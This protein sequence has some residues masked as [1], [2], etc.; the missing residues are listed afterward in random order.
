[1]HFTKTHKILTATVIALG[2][3]A[4]GLGTWALIGSGES[5]TRAVATHSSLDSSTTTTVPA[6]PTPPPTGA[7]SDGGADDGADD[8]GGSGGG[9]PADS[10]APADDGNAGQVAP[11]N[12]GQANAGNPGNGPIQNIPVNGNPQFQSP[13]VQAPSIAITSVMC[14]SLNVVVYFTASDPSGIAEVMVAVK[15]TNLLGNPN[16]TKYPAVNQILS[17]VYTTSFS[18]GKWQS[19]MLSIGAKD[20]YGNKSSIDKA[21]FCSA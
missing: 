5:D 4:T 11:E 20:T 1:M 21:S 12:P 15:T 16:P 14:D 8:G 17:G 10:G 3:T 2:L 7:T 6:A 19:S 13:D 9:A 18:A